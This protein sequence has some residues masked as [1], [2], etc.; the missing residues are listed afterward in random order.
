MA[1]VIRFTITGPPTGQS[2]SDPP[3]LQSSEW[4]TNCSAQQQR[5]RR[6]ADKKA[7]LDSCYNIVHVREQHIVTAFANYFNVI[8][9]RF[10]K[11]M[12]KNT[13]LCYV[14]KRLKQ[15]KLKRLLFNTI[16]DFI[17][18]QLKQH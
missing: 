4:L 13:K 9:N 6:L 3:V 15:I 14:L 8:C 16:Y 10:F 18:S 2:M 5:Q 12:S 1:I 17:G 11:T 7:A